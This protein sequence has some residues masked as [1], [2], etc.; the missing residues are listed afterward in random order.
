MKFSRT[1]IIFASLA[2]FWL[3][4]AAAALA[5]DAFLS[6]TDLWLRSDRME[7]K[8]SLAN[9]TALLLENPHPTNAL[10]VLDEDNFDTFVPM[11]KRQGEKLFELTAGGTNL[12]AQAVDVR[13]SSEGDA[14][15][16]TILYPR[17]AAGTVRIAPAYVKR[18]PDQGYGTALAV[19]D[20]AGHQLAFADNLNLEDINLD[21]KIPTTTNAPTVLKVEK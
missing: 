17:P 11:F 20:E 7:V 3:L 9:F 5:H 16:F 10:P 4:G 6:Y 2:A 19:F 14:V 1:K 15:D 21:F 8:C 13:L 18:L 12:V